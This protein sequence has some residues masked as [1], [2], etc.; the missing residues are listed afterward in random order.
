MDLDFFNTTVEEISEVYEEVTEPP[1]IQT[2]YYA[3]TS[4]E[5]VA[6]KRFK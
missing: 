1:E 2:V 5:V 3:N 6:T 4:I